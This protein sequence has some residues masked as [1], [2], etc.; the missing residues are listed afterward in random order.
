MSSATSFSPVDLN[1]HIKDLMEKSEKMLAHKEKRENKM[2]G[3]DISRDVLSFMLVSI[4]CFA[5][6]QR[7]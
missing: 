7:A 4:H 2:E 6:V 5:V 1:V 3:R